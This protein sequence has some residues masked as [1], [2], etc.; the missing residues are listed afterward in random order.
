MFDPAAA[1]VVANTMPIIAA[2]PSSAR[3][4][5]SAKVPAPTVATR[6]EPLPGNFAKIV[7][8]KSDVIID[9]EVVISAGTVLPQ[10]EFNKAVATYGSEKVSGTPVSTKGVIVIKDPGQVPGLTVNQSFDLSKA[11][12]AKV[13]NDLVQ[14]YGNK[15]FEAVKVDPAFQV[16]PEGLVPKKPEVVASPST[17]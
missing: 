13:Y 2:M 3:Q 5:L 7:V 12:D 15:A 8:V 16:T 14:E 10:N 9:G 1:S 6:P 4:S 11:E 17:P